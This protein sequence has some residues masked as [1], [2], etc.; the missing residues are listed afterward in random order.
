MF[1]ERELTAVNVLCLVC[2]AR[3]QSSIS[4]D[5]AASVATE[6]SVNTDSFA[7]FHVL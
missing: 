1:V 6:Q 5:V 4:S 7:F 3:L 2:L